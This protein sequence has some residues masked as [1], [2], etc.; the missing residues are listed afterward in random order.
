[1]IRYRI[2]TGVQTCA[3]PIFTVLK[4]PSLIAPR[5]LSARWE[6]P[7]RSTFTPTHWNEG[8]RLSIPLLIYHLQPSAVASRTR[9]II[10]TRD[11][12]EIG[13]AS[14]RERRGE[15]ERGG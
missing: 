11:S 5:R 13:R 3:L 12:K 10:T 14:C 15:E 4:I 6:A 9:H 8:R 7:S 1:G 2:V